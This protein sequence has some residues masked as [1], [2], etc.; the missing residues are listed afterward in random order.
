MCSKSMGLKYM[1]SYLQ[2]LITPLLEVMEFALKSQTAGYKELGQR[3]THVFNA[4][5]KTKKVCCSEILFSP[6]I[7]IDLCD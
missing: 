2:E 3:V 5:C 1:L 7:Q 6:Q 4:L